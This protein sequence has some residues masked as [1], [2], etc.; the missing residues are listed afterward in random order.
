[1]FHVRVV[2]T[3]SAAKAVQIVRY[4]KR[5]RIVVAHIGS[6]HCDEELEVL[7]STAQQWIDSRT[8]QLSVFSDVSSANI[9]LLDQCEYLGVY[10]TFLY[11]VLCKLQ[12]RIGYDG[13]GEPILNDLVTI[14]IMEPASKLRSIELIETYFGI[15]HRRQKFY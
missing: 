13:I 4:V 2:K 9:L 7:L 5:K 10:Y 1:M 15:K 3:A 11:D 14:R 8:Y 6:A 12:Q